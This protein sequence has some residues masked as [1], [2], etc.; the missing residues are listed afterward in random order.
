MNPIMIAKISGSHSPIAGAS[1]D[2]FHAPFTLKA[3]E[4]AAFRPSADMNHLQGKCLARQHTRSSCGTAT[5]LK[6]FSKIFLGWSLTQ[7][8]LQCMPAVVHRDIYWK[9]FMACLACL[10]QEVGERCMHVLHRCWANLGWI[11]VSA[12]LQAPSLSK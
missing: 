2:A 4:S 11:D 5:A 7:H 3:S 8:V 1:L 12:A 9:P 6:I 10:F